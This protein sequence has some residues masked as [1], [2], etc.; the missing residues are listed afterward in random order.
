MENKELILNGLQNVKRGLDRTL[1]TLTPEE[2]N[3]HPRSDANSIAIILFHMIRAEDSTQSMVQSKP[4]L[5]ETEKW[6]QKLNKASTDSG[7][8]YTA[9]QVAGF[10]I[11]V[12]ELMA[13]AEA[14]RKQTLEYLD[15]I[16]PEDFDKKLNLPPM[17]PPPAGAP[18]APP[19]PAFNFTVGTML[20][21]LVTHL[22]Q[23]AGEISYL[24]GLYRGLNK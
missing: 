4:Q 1:S 23:H 11:D 9:E 22:S 10:S 12:K 6:Y 21:M 24:R 5:W 18:P 2:L 17:P 3:W 14:L 15:K 7:S 13:Y 19:R 8:R 20:L 16:R